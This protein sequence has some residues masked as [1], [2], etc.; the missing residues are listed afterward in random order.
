MAI[1]LNMWAF[2]YI[3][4]KE[5]SFDAQKDIRK[6]YKTNFSMRR[7]MLNLV[8]LVLLITVIAVDTT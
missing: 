5:M 2:N 1:N 8:T 7:K 4:I 6:S 3:K